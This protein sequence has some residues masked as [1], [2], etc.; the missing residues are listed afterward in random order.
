MMLFSLL[1]TAVSNCGDGLKK[2]AKLSEYVGHLVVILEYNKALTIVQITRN[3]ICGE[4]SLC[5]L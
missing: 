4:L 3:T 1:G 2:L 5:F